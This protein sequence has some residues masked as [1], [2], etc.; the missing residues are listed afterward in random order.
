MQNKD[1]HLTTSLD[2]SISGMSCASCVAQVEKALNKLP[3]VASA[4]V[5]LATERAHIE[6]QKETTAE[7]IVQAVVD[8]GYGAEVVALHAHP[9]PEAQ[10]G[11]WH[12]AF[13]VALSLP[14]IV[15]MLL[16]LLGMHI[17]LPGWLQWLLATPIQFC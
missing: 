9:R 11:G 13:A 17:M 1:D 8:A 6:L 15:P 10:T 14:L 12:V 16:N 7:R 4:T 2:L 3:E 5:N